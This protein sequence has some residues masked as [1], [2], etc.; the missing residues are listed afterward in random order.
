MPFGSKPKNLAELIKRS[1]PKKAGRPLLYKTVDEQEEAHR[2]RTHKN[3]MA[4][5]IRRATER[6]GTPTSGAPRRR[7]TP[8]PR[9]ACASSCASPAPHPPT[10]S[11]AAVTTP[12]P[13]QEPHEATAHMETIHTEATS[14]PLPSHPPQGAAS[15]FTDPQDDQFWKDVHHLLEEQRGR[16]LKEKDRYQKVAKL[17]AERPCQQ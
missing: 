10:R 13:C 8:A 6:A 7:H 17:Y 9:A 3:K 14:H 5:R 1:R 2:V 12:T 16:Y 11:R 15:S 4:M